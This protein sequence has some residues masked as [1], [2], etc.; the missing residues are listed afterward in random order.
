[1]DTGYGAIKLYTRAIIFLENLYTNEK[2]IIMGK[3]KT[4]YYR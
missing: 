2:L 3:E 4:L 1:M